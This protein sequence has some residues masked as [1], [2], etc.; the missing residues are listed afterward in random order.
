MGTTGFTPLERPPQ[1][2][3]CLLAASLISVKDGKPR[4]LTTRDLLFVPGT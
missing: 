2:E 1:T 3:R 4:G